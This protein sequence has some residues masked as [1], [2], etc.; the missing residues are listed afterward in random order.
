[1]NEALA[2][3]VDNYQIDNKALEEYENE[4]NRWILER[5]LMPY[6]GDIK[7]KLSIMAVVQQNKGNVRLVIDY[8]R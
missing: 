5:W 3:G 7:V 4:V 2:K 1:M 8:R 6:S